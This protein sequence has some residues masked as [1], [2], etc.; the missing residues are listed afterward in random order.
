[1][2][3]G[4]LASSRPAAAG[5]YESIATVTVGSGGASSVSFSSIAAD[6]THLQIRGWAS[7][8]S[9]P[10]I[11]IRYNSDSGSNYTYHFLEGNGS[12]AVASAGANQTENWLFIN[13]FIAAN[14]PAPFVIDVLDYK[15]TN[16][17][18]TMKA[19]HGND[20]NSAGYISLA[21]GLWR[22]TSAISSIELRTSSSTFSQYSTFAL[23]GIKSA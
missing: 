23:Y 4:I 2:L 1:M 17:F 22:S 16:K 11:Y 8:A 9:T 12:S 5:D 20:N 19:L 7:S 10:R 6:W 3:L 21:S 14:N 18:K 13:G 15:D